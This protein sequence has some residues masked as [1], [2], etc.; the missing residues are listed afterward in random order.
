MRLPV[1]SRA[2]FTGRIRSG[3]PDAW[4]TS[5]ASNAHLAIGL[6]WWHQPRASVKLMS[7]VSGVVIPE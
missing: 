7:S 3:L 2:G 1:A 5:T 4:R 6:P